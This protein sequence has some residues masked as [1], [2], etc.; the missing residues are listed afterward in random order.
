MLWIPGP[1]EVRDEI[2]AELQRPMIGH[3]SAEMKAVIERIDPGLRLAFGLGKDSTSMAGVGTHSATA[4]MEG[5]LTGVG[6]RVLCIVA[7]AF[8]KRWAEVARTLGKEVTVLEVPWG[9]AVDP[10][11]LRD[12]L[13]NGAPFDA[14]T[15][16]VNETSTGVLTPLGPV[17]EALKDSPRTLLLV[18]VVSAIAGSPIDFDEHRID[19]ALAGVNKALALPPGITV[20][21]ASERYLA[22]AR[23]NERR[24]WYLDPVR[25]LE[26]HRDRKTPATPNV[27][28]YFAL[29]RQLEDI[30]AGRTLPEDE[31]HKS[32]AAAWQARFEKHGR[33]RE[34]TLSWAGDHGLAPYPE[35]RLSSPTV[36][37]F[38]AGDLD[39]AR[40]VEGLAQHGE[41]IGTGYGD[42][43]WETFRIGH[44]GDHT[45]EGL[46]R[47]LTLADEVIADLR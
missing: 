24:T 2:L 44:M 17:A 31:R 20:L 6:P 16:V 13:G 46:A 8:S 27:P 45:E 19:F 42:L 41:R 34:R 11:Q 10:D 29:A 15:L 40:L 25:T 22:A 47:L 4:M 26:G 35:H 37:C 18:D 33:M 23:G 36:S 7:G 43:K 39:V 3:R 21:C 28:L 12:T 32:G 5:S 30:S 38:R 14:V 1:T 9:Q